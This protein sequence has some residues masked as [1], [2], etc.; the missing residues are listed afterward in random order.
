MDESPGKEEIWKKIII[1][2]IICR[3]GRDMDEFLKKVIKK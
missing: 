1:K 2:K 3:K